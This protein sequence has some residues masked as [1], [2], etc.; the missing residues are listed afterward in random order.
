MDGRCTGCGDDG[1]SCCLQNRLCNND[2][3]ICAS[4]PMDMSMP[5]VATLPGAQLPRPRTCQ[6]CGEPGQPCCPVNRC[7]K[8]GCCARA[9]SDDGGTC[10]AAGSQ[11]P[12]GG[13]CAAAGCGTCGKPGQ[14]CC[15]GGC[16]APNTTCKLIA[17]HGGRCMTCGGR[18]EPC[19]ADP[20][21]A[22]Y[23]AAQA[24]ACFA[25]NLSCRSGFCVES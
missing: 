23:I 19:C 20:T 12:S 25:N 4:V 10:V 21:A 5:P 1:Q 7:N 13:A 8:D 16:T 11:C 15:D 24:G 22:G 2:N 3:A 9:G 17:G 18:G 6:V 14:P